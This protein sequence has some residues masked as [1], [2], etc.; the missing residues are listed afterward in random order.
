M[1]SIL[2]LF[3]DKNDRNEIRRK[4][5]E[6]H[7]T[8]SDLNI[9]HK[10]KMSVYCPWLKDYH[11]CGGDGFI[12]LP[13]QYTGNAAPNPNRLLK[14][15]K[16]DADV[17]IMSSLRK[18]IRINA[19]CSDGKSY[20]FLVKYGEDLRQD[21]RIQQIQQLMSDQM[22]CDRNCNQQ[23]LSLRTYKV[24][25]LNKVCGIISWIENIDAVA[26]V[27]RNSNSNWTH[28]DRDVQTLYETFLEKGNKTVSRNE[29]YHKAVVGYTPE[30][31][32]SFSSIPFPH[33][34]IILKLFNFTFSLRR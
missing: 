4:V 1:N 34:M 32:R 14:I 19:I 22:K 3:L 6:L 26:S 17:Q 30:E 20:G 8:L 9:L 28:K 2:H 12:E 31:V 21:D 23:K 10:E 11:W 18:P 24:I 7:K 29:L 25:P 15:V 5:G 33:K 13:G 27:L 16:F